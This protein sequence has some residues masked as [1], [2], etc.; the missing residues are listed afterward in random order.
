MGLFGKQRARDAAKIAELQEKLNHVREQRDKIRETRDKLKYQLA[1]ARATLTDLQSD[2]QNLWVQ[3]FRDCYDLSTPSREIVAHIAHRKDADFD[4]GL[5]MLM[6]GYLAAQRIGG[7]VRE[8]GLKDIRRVLDFGCGCARVTR[9]LDCVGD[10]A[11]LYGCDID[12]EAIDWCKKHLEN[13]GTFFVS[14]D[15]PPLNQELPEFDVI[16]VLSVFTHLPED[17]QFEWLRA[18]GKNLR[19]GGLMLA[20]VHG[21]SFHRFIPNSLRPEFEEKG[22]AYADLGKTPDLPDY[23]LSTFHSHK[24]VHERWPDTGFKVRRIL[25]QAVPQATVRQDLVVLEKI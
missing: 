12:T 25:E 14:P 23:Y 22:F 7:I 24:Y 8:E 18:L 11:E 21:P 17:M 15:R 20:T 16:V 19:V 13:V 1:E 9:F 5:H 3:H 2:H 4:D 6:T 10:E